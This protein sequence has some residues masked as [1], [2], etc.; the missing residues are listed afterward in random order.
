MRQIKFEAERKLGEMLKA[1][2]KKQGA[3]GSKVTG[4]KRENQ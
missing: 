2:Q 1:T 4:S 3:K